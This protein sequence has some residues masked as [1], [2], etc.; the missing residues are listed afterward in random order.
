MTYD[1]AFASIFP[2]NT[3]VAISDVRDAARGEVTI[4]SGLSETTFQDPALVKRMTRA[5]Q[6]PAHTPGK[7][8]AT[9][10]GGVI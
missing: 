1:P 3:T 7:R 9:G 2:R 4:V 5:A 10:V 6:H 8:K